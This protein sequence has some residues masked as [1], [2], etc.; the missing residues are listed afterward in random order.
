MKMPKFV[1]TYHGEMG[2]PEDPAEMQAVMDQW[3]AWYGSIG[4]ALV[5]GGAPFGQNTAVGPDGS[6]I[7]PPS[8]LS[9][10]TIVSADDAAGAAKIAQGCPVLGH[11]H[12][13]QISES[14]EM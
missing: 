9:G 13:V 14:I 11:G 6:M 7:D 12:T 1:L 3:G 8:Q 5:D 10:Y 2:M 4:E